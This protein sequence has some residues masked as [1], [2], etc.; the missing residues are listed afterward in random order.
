MGDTVVVLLLVHY[1]LDGQGVE[2]S[3]ILHQDDAA[4][5]TLHNPGKPTIAA[6][7]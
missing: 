2:A 5:E 6:R 7:G 4:V 1:M 3:D